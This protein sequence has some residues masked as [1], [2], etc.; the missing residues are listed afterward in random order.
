MSTQKEENFKRL[1]ENRTNKIINMLHLLG[2]LSNTS[3]YSYS[4][5]QIET[6]FVAIEQELNEQKNRFNIKQETKKKF[7]L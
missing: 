6:I 1:A 5:E 7:R 2:N 4:A 3:N